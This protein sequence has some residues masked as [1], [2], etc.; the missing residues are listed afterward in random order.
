MNQQQRKFLIEK[1]EKKTK[2]TVDALKSSIPDAPSF[3]NYMMHAVMSGNY[4]IIDK[5]AIKA[6]ILKKALNS[7]EGRSDWMGDS[8][9]FGSRTQLAFK[10]KEIFIVPE[11]YTTIHNEYA[12]KRKQ[13]EDDIAAIQIQCDTLVTRIQLASDKTLQKMINEVDDMGDISL[14]DTTLKSIS[15]GTNDDKL[16][17]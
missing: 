10:P 14:I 8:Q 11:E 9:A 17:N 2:I 3:S 6:L 5:D 1:I 13:I 4:D 15:Q 16:L 12:A 7:K